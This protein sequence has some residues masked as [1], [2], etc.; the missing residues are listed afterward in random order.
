MKLNTYL[1]KIKNSLA[2]FKAKNL[3]N[4]KSNLKSQYPKIKKFKIFKLK[5]M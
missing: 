4:L 3:T 5:V 2:V 1:V